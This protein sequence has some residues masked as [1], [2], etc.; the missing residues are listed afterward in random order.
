MDDDPWLGVS[1]NLDALQGIICQ[2]FRVSP[3]E[4]GQ[5]IPI[6]SQLFKNYAQ[7]YSFQI[8]P[9]CDAETHSVV[10][11][12][13]LPVKP[14]FKTENEV[15][16]MDF[17]RNHTTLP[18]P[19][20][21]AYCS[22][23]NN[24]VGVE[25][26]LMEHMP[27][28]EMGE[29]WEQLDYTQKRT[30]ALDLVDLYDQLSRLK[31]DGCGGIYHKVVNSEDSSIPGTTIRS[32]SR[33]LRWSSLSPE[34]LRA[35][36]SHCNHKVTIK[37][38]YELGPLNDISL[39]NYRLTVPTPSQTMPIF[40]SDEYVKL[41]AFNGNP[42]TR[43]TYDLPTREK[44]VELFQSI[45]KLYPNSTV[46][47]PSA[48][49]CKFCF[50]H[51]DLH[52]GNIL[53][54]PQSGIITGII[55]W[56]SAAFRPLWAEVRGVGWFEEGRQRFIFGSDPPGDFKDDIDPEDVRLRAF[57]R[58]EL[59]KRNPELY[60]A[61]VGGVELRAVVHAAADDPRPIGETDIFLSRYYRYE[62]PRKEGK[63]ERYWEERRRG[64]FPWDMNAWRHRRMDLDEM[65]MKQEKL[66]ESLNGEE[67]R[68]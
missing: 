65:L 49:A 24:P 43:S 13:V 21:Y 33:S 5:P 54:D 55:D 59:H 35:L 27:G 36:R 41:I 28:V 67:I 32:S 9:S 34:F 60:S 30:L 64:P 15:A 50:S 40:T 23:S 38:H 10:A 61:F 57:F 25:W 51:G 31:A 58:T 37:N 48:D 62:L 26:I 11:R 7:V 56:E 44:C 22:D 45:Y 12:L 18:V 53:I 14:L 19:K 20:V 39:V 2:V 3:H 52:D 42:S 17:V 1:I 63:K 68:K 16:A 29:G 66:L 8:A 6:G 4:V 46:F 47:G